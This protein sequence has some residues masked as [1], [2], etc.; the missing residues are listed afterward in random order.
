MTLKTEYAKTIKEREKD[1]ALNPCDA[2]AFSALGEALFELAK[3]TDDEKLYYE[4]VDRYKKAVELAP[5][6]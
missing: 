3:L 2:E 5:N 1:I 6:D 4:S